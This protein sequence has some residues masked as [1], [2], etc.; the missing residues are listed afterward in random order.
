[1]GGLTLFLE[2]F[3][4]AR[5]ERE[6][7]ALSDAI[8]ASLQ[9]QMLQRIPELTQRTLEDMGDAG[10]IRRIL[11]VNPLGRVAHAFPPTER[12]RVLERATDP[13]CRDCHGGGATPRS[14]TA[15]VTGPDGRRA[16]RIATPIEN[17]P[18]CQGCH[19]TSARLNGM[20][21]IERSAE[22][23]TAALG[24]IRARMGLTWA[25]TLAV[26]GALIVGATTV[27]V[28]R[29]VRRLIEGAR[30]I[31]GGDLSTRVAVRGRGEI[32]ELG[33][34]LNA[35]AG[36]L[37]ASLDELREKSLELSVLYSIVDRLSRSV[38][39]AE[40]KPLVLEAV[41]E[42]LRS[43]RVV[44]VCPGIEPDALEVYE[45]SAAGEVHR[46]CA[47]ASELERSKLPVAPALV[48]RWAA[49]G[50]AEVD[51][52]RTER[53]AILPL[54]FRDSDLGLL[55]VAE[56]P[57]R[58][59]DADDLRLM[60]A[61]RGHVSVAFENARLYTLAITDELTQ[62]YS[63][64]HF[65]VSLAEAMRRFSRYGEPVALL[66]LDLDHFKAVN[67]THGHPA[68]DAVLREVARRVRAS[69]R[70]V[71]LACRYGGEEF[72]VILSHTDAVGAGA[73]AER[74]RATVAGAPV[75]LEAGVG[76]SVTTSVGVAICPRDATTP[77]GFVHAADRAL[78]RAKRSGRNRVCAAGEP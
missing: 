49:G 74:I 6:T 48:A 35:M 21:L 30:R 23:E 50:L 34:T 1:M 52:D 40:L 32:A 42:V 16:F 29:P 66:M 41:A 76:L 63:P 60:G 51:V 65:Q 5:I 44:L 47:H 8:R 20:L 45:R 7:A 25:A 24:T 2:E 70:D 13:P 77:E 46:V 58:A 31:G 12:G 78:Y 62:L 72:G 69:V 9:Q 43:P 11:I 17:Q 67:D 33:A 54:R 14:R 61:L 22:A 68:G 38:F 75:V 57:E 28:H 37:A 4:R 3:F 36:D 19:G 26:L 53:L 10:D 64:R 71:D 15:L 59:F 39:I 73:V 27:L 55:V 18:R 56:P